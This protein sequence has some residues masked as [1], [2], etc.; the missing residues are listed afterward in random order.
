MQIKADV[1]NKPI[2]ALETPD[3]GTAGSAMLAGI[4]A[5]RFGNLRDA[6]ACLVHEA[7]TYYPREEMHE[8]YMRIYERYKKMYYAVRPLIE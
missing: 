6:A 3:A 7:E 5:G 2:S 8:R 4:A 1:L